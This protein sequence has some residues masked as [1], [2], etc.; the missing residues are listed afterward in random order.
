MYYIIALAVSLVLSVLI[1][2]FHPLVQTR[3]N[4]VSAVQSMHDKQVSRLGGLAV[5]VATFSTMLLLP[6][7]LL[8][9]RTVFLLAATTVPVLIA[10]ILEDLGLNVRPRDR[11]LAACG[12]GVLYIIL[13][14]Q[15]LMS[16]HTPVL[17]YLMQ[18]A[19]FA[20][21][22]SVLLSA[23]VSHAYN[24][25][26]GLNGFAGFVAGSAALSLGYLAYASGLA[27]QG[28]MLVLTFSATVGFLMVNFPSGRIFLG[29][30]GAYVVGHILVWISIS[31]L[32]MAP[33]VS[34]WSILLI[35]FWP[36]A[37]T[38]LAIL[39]RL[40]RGGAIHHPDRLHF[41]HLALRALEIAFLGRGNRRLANPIASVILLPFAVAPMLAGVLLKS[42]NAAAAFAAG[43]FFALFLI[44]YKTGVVVASRMSTRRAMR[45]VMIELKLNAPFL[46][47]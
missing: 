16:T 19:P 44:T 36:L 8:D 23:G 24:L 47:N 17:D 30:A 21:L 10:G 35:F 12:S 42:S 32:W 4:D 26:D 9:K 27:D 39:R 1:V 14:D 22:F 28:V 6:A 5:V 3:R 18:W 20:I 45:R 34:A 15:W 46:K 13:F 41:H 2:H 31:L 37:D 40:S 43:A 11:F 7:E 29:D 38:A 25:I 33:E